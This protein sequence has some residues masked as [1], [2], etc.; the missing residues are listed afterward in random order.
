MKTLLLIGLILTLVSTAYR[1][2]AWLI[3]LISFLKG[4]VKTKKA[5]KEMKLSKSTLYLSGLEHIIIFI[6]V[7]IATIIIF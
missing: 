1:I 7:L 3:S 4:D 2:F 6:S 5:I